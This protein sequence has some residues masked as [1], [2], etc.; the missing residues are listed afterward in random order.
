MSLLEQDGGQAA[1]PPQLSLQSQQQQ[2]QQGGLA[3]PRRRST[4]QEEGP[5]GALATSGSPF[6]THPPGTEAAAA[7]GG[8]SMGGG[9][10]GSAGAQ[11]GWLM[12]LGTAVQR[13]GGGG[14]ASA[15]VAPGSSEEEELQRAIQLSM[16][17]ERQRQAAGAV[18]AAPV[19]VSEEADPELPPD[20]D[21]ACPE[22][23]AATPRVT[24]GGL[25]APG[26][27]AAA[28]AHEAE[29]ADLQRALELSLL[30]QQRG[31]AGAPGASSAPAAPGGQQQLRSG[32]QAPE[33]P[34]DGVA[35][36]PAPC[37]AE[38]VEDDARLSDCEE[39]PSPALDGECA[40][41]VCGGSGASGKPP[42]AAYRLH[43]VVNHEGPAASC[44]HFTADVR[45][46]G[47]GAWH[48]FSDSLATRI[49]AAD[50]CG[51]RRQ[52]ECYMLFYVHAGPAAGGSP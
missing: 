9:T 52:R 1:P 12:G 4:G 30:E 7:A 29:D 19:V 31:Q 47:S 20:A 23:E 10:E 49:G 35:P 15:A 37:P 40:A 51:G 34:G 24:C 44:G 28:A 14:P 27:A 2:Q 8:G 3:G 32:A 50:A 48:S 33:L 36:A 16:L 38:I 13:Q 6:A 21:A 11:E 43:A 22:G 46:P 45:H 41:P 25:P 39:G 42:P 5:S 18:V 17:E 26:E